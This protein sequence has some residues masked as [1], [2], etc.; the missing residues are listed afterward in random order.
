MPIG[1]FTAPVVVRVANGRPVEL[2]AS[3]DDGF[4]AL[5]EGSLD[6]FCIE[7]PDWHVA[8]DKL[9]RAKLNPSDANVE[10]ARE[11]LDALVKRLPAH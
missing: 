9:A 6:G 1:Q 10:S 4:T 7:D 3:I 8:F 2:I 5:I 11:A